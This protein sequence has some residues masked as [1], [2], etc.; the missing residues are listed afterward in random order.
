MKNRKL[1]ISILIF[2]TIIIIILF[3]LLLLKRNKTEIANSNIENSHKESIQEYQKTTDTQAYFTIDERIKAYMLLLKNNS[4]I[5]MSYLNE[6]YIKANNINESNVFQSLNTY[7]NYDSYITGQMYVA[8]TDDYLSYYVK[9]RIDGKEIFFNVNLDKINK[10]F[11]ITPLTNEKYE[12]DI[13]NPVNLNDFENKTIEGKQYNFFNYK[14][15]EYSE[16]IV[17]RLYYAEYIRAM[18]VDSQEA[19]NLLDEEFKKAKYNSIDMFREFIN[20][21][22]EKIQTLYKMETSKSSD[23][24]DF[25]TYNDYK[26]KNYL[27]AVKS[28]AIEKYD[29]YTQYICVD[30]YDNY[31]IFN[32]KYPGDYTV[33][34]DKYS[35][36]TP[37]FIEKYNNSTGGNKVAMNAEKIKSAINCKDYRYVYNKLDDTF[38]QNN[39]PRLEDF[40]NYI[41]NNMF[42]YNKFNYSEAK[43]E[44][45]VYTLTFYIQDLEMI[46]QQIKNGTIIMQ[47]KEGTDFVMSFSFE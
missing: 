28:Y 9:G 43:K 23:F 42:E 12:N 21:N 4:N 6:A 31:F 15:I 22:R 5:V 20:N 24:E 37:K 34:L 41:K 18:L 45:D 29:D 47:L 14:G 13:N 11:D 8:G 16:E 44:S 1:I 2:I 7:Q 3:I 30:G 39:Y 26:N 36:D 46:T 38:K 25:N 10:T 35:I 32:V 33:M 17:A 19:Y 40:E 27:Y